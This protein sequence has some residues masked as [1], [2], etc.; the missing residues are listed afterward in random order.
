M[1]FK[2][3]DSMFSGGVDTMFFRGNTLELDVILGESI[4]EGLENVRC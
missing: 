1:I 4:L 3:P 2:F